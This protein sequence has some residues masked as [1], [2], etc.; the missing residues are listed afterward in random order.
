MWCDPSSYD[1]KGEVSFLDLPRRDYGFLCIH[2]E[3]KYQ[4]VLSCFKRFIVTSD[5]KSQTYSSSQFA[6]WSLLNSRIPYH[7]KF[8]ETFY[9]PISLLGATSFTIEL[10]DSCSPD[11]LFALKNMKFQLYLYADSTHCPEKF[12]QLSET[13]Q[14]E[15]KDFKDGLLTHQ[16]DASLFK[17][18][19]LAQI[20]CYS[21]P[22][23]ARWCLAGSFF[24]GN[25]VDTRTQIAGFRTPFEAI[26]LDKISHGLSVPN[27][28]IFTFTFTN[29]KTLED[30]I[31]GPPIFLTDNCCLEVKIDEQHLGKGFP[32]LEV[33]FVFAR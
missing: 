20:V 23:I 7:D 33:F 14:I 15:V 26:A 27:R 28:P 32:V 10:N 11:Q 22:E 24:H 18:K 29:F 21:N 4:E 9:V 6:V 2:S 31:T 13:F 3:Q 30:E 12:L 8:N 17:G 25:D 1:N 5:R 16:F 19:R